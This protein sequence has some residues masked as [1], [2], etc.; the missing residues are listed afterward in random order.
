MAN[1]HI[2]DN[3][4]PFNNGVMAM[5]LGFRDGLIRTC[6]RNHSVTVLLNTQST[7]ISSAR[8]YSRYGLSTVP[9][10][11]AR[12]RSGPPKCGRIFSRLLPVT[13]R[14]WSWGQRHGIRIAHLGGWKPEQADIVV[15]LCGEDYFS[16]NWPLSLCKFADIQYSF[17]KKQGIPNVIMAQTF[18]PFTRNYSRLLAEKHLAQAAL[19]TAR[20]DVSFDNVTEDLGITGHVHRTG[21]LAFLMEPDEWNKVEQRHT[22][23]RLLH[24]ADTQWVGVSISRLFARSV[25][26]T[27]FSQSKRVEA[28]F[29]QF[30]AGL[31]SILDQNDDIR[32]LFTPHVTEKGNDDRDADQEVI[33]RMKLSNRIVALRDEYAA[34]E[35]KAVIGRCDAFIGCRMHALIAAVSQ[36]VPTLPLAYSPKTMDV[37]G[38]AMDYPFVMDFRNMDP[39]VVSCE[40]ARQFTEI[41]RQ[42]KKLRI[43]LQEEEQKTKA[44]SYQ[45]FELLR[46][47]LQNITPVK[48]VKYELL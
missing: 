21:D 4:N 13:G 8:Q 28:F 43:K 36:T 40:L 41:W 29:V 19:V 10:G 37:I 9:N 33:Q 26:H 45:N 18:G 38:K 35:I 44:L 1:I 23:L 24:F 14:F 39:H 5:A 30:A 11:L 46:P 12:W 48:L 42:R 25:F 7:F 32:I 31:D 6:G 2:I 17:F 47:I 15:S 27:F 20:D 22:E 16:D 34:P 3:G